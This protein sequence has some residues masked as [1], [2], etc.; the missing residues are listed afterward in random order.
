MWNLNYE[1]DDVELVD[2]INEIVTNRTIG[3]LFEEEYFLC[4][5]L[6]SKKVIDCIVRIHLDKEAPYIG[7]NSI[8]DIEQKN[9]FIKWFN[10]KGKKLFAEKHKQ[11]KQLGYSA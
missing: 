8:E 5:F 7:F 4:Y 6:S 2:Q 11:I 10:L 9:N 3:I 1:I